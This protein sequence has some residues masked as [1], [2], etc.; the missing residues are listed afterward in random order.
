LLGK[1]P[2]ET[3]RK[4]VIDLSRQRASLYVK[5]SVEYST[6]V[7][8]GKSGYA[9]PTGE[10]VVTNKHRHWTSTIYDASMPYF[11]RLNCGSFGLHEGYVP[12]YPASHGCI[13]VPGGTARKLFS[14]MEVGDLVSIVR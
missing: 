7:S 8:T 4:I 14:V 1:E 9:T 6:P 13:R 12:D 3:D 2:G 10:Y 11:M 5:G